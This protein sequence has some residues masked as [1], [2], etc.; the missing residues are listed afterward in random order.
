MLLGCHVIAGLHR[1][2]CRPARHDLHLR[3]GELGV[4][5]RAHHDDLVVLSGAKHR[6][7]EIDTSEIIVDFQ[8]HFP[9]FRFSAVFSQ[10]IVTFPV[11]F[12][13][14]LPINFQWHSPT[15]FHI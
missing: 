2:S 15:Q 3:L 4:R 7:P 1:E 6:T 10:R 12:Y 14:K 8:W 13:Q 11:D 5:L 9:D